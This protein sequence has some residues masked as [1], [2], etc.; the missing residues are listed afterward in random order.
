MRIILFAGK[1]GVGKTSIAAATGLRA[2]QLGHRTLVMSLDAAHSLSDSF[3]LDKRLM[4]INKGRPAQVAENLWIQEIDTQEEI[5]KNWKDVYQY[6]ATLISASG[7]EEILAEELAIIPGMEEVSSLLYINRYAS[8]NEFDTILLDCA[9]TG[10]SIRFIS[11][12][13]ALEWYMK[14]LFKVERKL[15]RYVRPV[16]ERVYDLPLPEDEYFENIQI[17]FQRLEG[18][19]KLL[20]N[21]RITSVR[22]ATNPEKIVIKETQRAFMYFSLYGLCIDAVIINRVFPDEISDAYFHR[23]MGTQG[24]HIQES[25]RYFDPV[26]IFKLALFKDEV[27]G[28]KDLKEL[29]HQL[30]GKRDPTEVFFAE[31]PYKFSKKDGNYYLSIKLPFTTKEDLDLSKSGEELILRIGGVKRHIL[32]PKNIAHLTP[33]GAKIK[34]ENLTISFGGKKDG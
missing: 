16:A 1:G 9:P 21:P 22:L 25:E 2:A 10:E 5:Q 30:Y 17:L 18:V 32:L 27:V 20:T 6:T 7:I 19:E 15:T 34:G 14:K 11:I 28:E 12:P 4:D 26:P 23:W 24:R 13:T 3:D 33:L 31:S 8:Q 29:A